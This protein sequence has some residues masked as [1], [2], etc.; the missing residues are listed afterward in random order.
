MNAK[1]KLLPYFVSILK[2]S[3]G[4]Q[5]FLLLLACTIDCA[6]CWSFPP[7]APSPSSM[8]ILTTC[9]S[10]K[11]SLFLLPC[12]SSFFFFPKPLPLLRQ[13]S[14]IQN[15]FSPLHAHLAA[16]VF[17]FAQNPAPF[18]VSFS[19]R[20]SWFVFRWETNCHL[21]KVLQLRCNSVRLNTRKNKKV[22]CNGGQMHMRV[23]PSQSS[24]K[25]K[26]FLQTV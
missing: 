3:S 11:Q 22:N 6:S 18:S 26:S 13:Q 17:F 23:E 12:W 14:E 5:N 4:R 1:S 7:P 16:V 2:S 15:L 8:E 9:S 10:K 21:L 25:E 20:Q 24:Q 19:K